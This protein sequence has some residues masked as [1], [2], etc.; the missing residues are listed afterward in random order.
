M[1]LPVASSAVD[2]GVARPH[3]YTKVV[4]IAR[5]PPAPGALGWKGQGCTERCSEPGLLQGSAA[6]ARSKGL[7]CLSCDPQNDR[8]SCPRGTDPQARGGN[9]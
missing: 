7:C 1:S 8:A 6:G 2:S 9:R 4:C 5:C 3:T